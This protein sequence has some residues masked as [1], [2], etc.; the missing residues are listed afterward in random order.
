[1][2]KSPAVT[3]AIARFH[4]RSAQPRKLGSNDCC[5]GVAD[6][7]AAAWGVDPLARF[8][9]RYSSLAGARRILQREGC[10]TFLD[11]LRLAAADCW[12]VEMESGEKPRDFDLGLI[13]FKNGLRP[14]GSLFATPSFYLD[15]LWQAMTDDGLVA[16]PELGHGG[17][18]WRLR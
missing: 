2:S 7:L 12:A 15:G 10:D 4:E 13:I 5:T 11:G 18:K 6:V 9:G 3:A 17:R 16:V 14:D 1:M 8:A